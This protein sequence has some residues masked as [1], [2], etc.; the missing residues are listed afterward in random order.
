[1]SD[2][3]NT[4][5]NLTFDNHFS[6]LPSDF[7]RHVTPSPLKKPH[8]VSFST[9]AAQLIGLDPAEA[10]R[11]EFIDYFNGKTLFSDSE[12]LAMLYSG[13]QFGQYVSQLGDGRAMMLGEVMHKGQGW[14]LQLKGS[15]ETPY[16]RSGDGRAVL[17]STIREYLCSEAMAGLGIPT[18]R[19]LCIIGSEEE[20]CRER[21]ETGAMLLRMAP[22][23]IRFGS[24]EIFFHRRQFKQ[25]KILADYVIQRYYPDCL[26]NDNPYLSLLEAVIQRTAKMIAQWQLV[27]F[28]HGV[29]NTDNMSVLG[30]TLD[31]G[32][33]GFLDRYDPHYICNYSDYHGRYAFD[34]QPTIGLWNLNQFAQ[35]LLPLIEQDNSLEQAVEKAKA[36][37]QGY[38]PQYENTFGQ[39]MHDKL[40][41]QNNDIFSEKLINDIL[42]KLNENHVDYTRFFS[43]LSMLNTD[44]KN[45]QKISDKK[46][47]ELFLDPS[48]F[49]QWAINYRLSLKQ[50]QRNDASR[51]KAMK[52]VNPHYILRNHLAQIAIEKAEQ[53]DFSEVDRLLVLL[54]KPFIQQQDM[55]NYAERPP[56]W[57]SK[58]SISCSS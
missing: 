11:T 28:T 31:Y 53:G 26:D 37:L 54:Q 12:P 40:G 10:Q 45:N 34:Q 39:G 3:A 24:F 43:A 25:L 4:L 58:I 46:I 55:E 33:F 9:N 20:V 6:R 18:T 41:L 1:M 42:H 52:Q 35:S 49:D 17:R 56:V 5:E 13:H 27:G 22:S 57:A 2:S 30:L 23:H 19:A 29:M 16:S 8:L 44:E 14:E 15:G 36:A 7:Y 38:Q 48:A 50:E 32:P 51:H 47:R 21:I